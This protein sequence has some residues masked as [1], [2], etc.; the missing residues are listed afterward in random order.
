MDFYEGPND[1]SNTLLVDELIAAGTTVP[2]HD[3][4]N[5]SYASMTDASLA[6]YITDNYANGEYIVFV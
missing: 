6:T 4:N 5:T 1:A 3:P 2:A